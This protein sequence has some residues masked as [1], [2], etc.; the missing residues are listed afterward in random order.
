MRLLFGQ[1]KP[2]EARHLQDGLQRADN[3]YPG[4]NGYRPVQA[5]DAIAEALPEEFQGGATFV[6]GDGTVSL[7]AGTATDLYIFDAGLEWT[8]LEGSLT[9]NRWYFTQFGDVAICTNGG[10]PVAVDLLAGTADPLTVSPPDAFLCTTVRNFVV[11]GN[12]DGEENMVRWSGF[13][14]HTQWVNGT[15]QA[16]EQPMLTGGA[17]T[18][19][20]GGEYGMVFQRGQISRMQYVGTEGGLDI[21]WQFD[22]I[23]AN[24][25]C[26]SPGSVAQSGR[27]VFFLSDRG[28]MKTD[29][30][31]VSPIGAERID[32]TFLDSYSAEDIA[33][34]YATVDPKNHIVVWV[35]PGKMWIYN[36]Q[37]DQ[38]STSEWA[39]KAALSGFT[40]GVSLDELDAIFGDLDAM[41]EIS[42]DDGRFKGGAPLL[43]VVNSS[44]EIG[45]LT[46]DN[47]EA[48]I[49]PPFV[50]MM[51]GRATRI[52]QVR[53]LTDAIEGLTIRFDAKPR[54][55]D[56]STAQGFAIMQDSGDIPCRVSGRNI[57]PT[58][59]I[60]AGTAW[61][62]VQ[63]LDFLM[64]AAG[65]R[66]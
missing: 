27:L 49:E 42:L 17:I 60:A 59:V 62:Y 41:G 8:S 20:A 9:A 51:R 66:R 34:M 19:L 25:G 15:N 40:P 4:T 30:T 10:A 38:W 63:G 24:I 61:S 29:G 1:L 6:A 47:L 31:D 2:D 44:D 50:E 5:F 57:R 22:I 54:L 43:L 28:F 52:S 33:A 3:V 21:I 56:S 55:G 46:G 64:T 13:E 39:V 37:L 32:R 36:Y 48:T 12:V 53:P 35:M 23:S 7:L 11:L 45:T 58:T 14:N 16:G 65:G 18:G 26:I